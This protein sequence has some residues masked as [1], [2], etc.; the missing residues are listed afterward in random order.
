MFLAKL[1]EKMTC[2]FKELEFGQALVISECV[3]AK[4]LADFNCGT[5]RLGSICVHHDATLTKAMETGVT[6]IMPK[7]IVPFYTWIECLYISLS[8]L[9]KPKNNNIIGVEWSRRFPSV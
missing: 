4:D 1:E 2:K 8:L 5:E 6:G 3:W 9:D 7:M